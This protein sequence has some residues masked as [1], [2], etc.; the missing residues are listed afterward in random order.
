VE[1]RVLFVVAL[2]KVEPSAVADW[3]KCSATPRSGEVEREKSEEKS[4][5]ATGRRGV[6]LVVVAAAAVMVTS[7]MVPGVDG[8]SEREG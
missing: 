4:T 8:E 2:F 3:G 7:G 1:D 6:G 5:G